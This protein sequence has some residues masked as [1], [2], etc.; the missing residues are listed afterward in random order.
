M[1]DAII[2]DTSVWLYTGRIG[3]IELLSRLFDPVYTTETVCCELDDGR[4][5]RSDTPDVRQFAWVRIVQPAS[6][7]VAKLPANRLGPGEQS[8]L[9]YA[10]SIT[11]TGS[12][13]QQTHHLYPHSF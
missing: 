9:A 7:D 6:Q 3:Q 13:V 1:P 4:L 10:F 5:S 12:K 11:S 8:V 2:C